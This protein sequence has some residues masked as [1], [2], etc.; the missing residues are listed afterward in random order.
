MKA[1]DILLDPHNLAGQTVEFWASSID[2]LLQ[3]FLIA[4]ASGDR[5][6]TILASARVAQLSGNMS[7]WFKEGTTGLCKSRDEVLEANKVCAQVADMAKARMSKIYD[8]I[9]GEDDDDGEDP[10]TVRTPDRT[11]N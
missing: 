4:V 6:A 3:D 8:G 10:E 2:A 5:M 9:N 7:D 11:A 1:D